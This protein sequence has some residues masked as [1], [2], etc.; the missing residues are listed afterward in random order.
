[1]PS[2]CLPGPCMSASQSVSR[3]YL[4]ISSPLLVPHTGQCGSLGTQHHSPTSSPFLSDLIY[5]AGTSQTLTAYLCPYDLC[6]VFV[7]CYVNMPLSLCICASI[8]TSGYGFPQISLEGPSRV[9]GIQLSALSLTS[10]YLYPHCIARH[11]HACIRASLQRLGRHWRLVICIPLLWSVFV[12]R[13]FLVGRAS[14]VSL[15]VRIV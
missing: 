8:P 10:G 1:M 9:L 15:R 3:S 5:V 11:M 12:W 2:V 6:R 4:V 7:T 13:W 14:Q